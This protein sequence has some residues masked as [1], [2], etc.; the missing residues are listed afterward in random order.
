MLFIIGKLDITILCNYKLDT[1]QY[2]VLGCWPEIL[3]SLHHRMHSTEKVKSIMC[4]FAPSNKNNII[5]LSI[6]I[7]KNSKSI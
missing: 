2:Y 4:W 1:L 6:M 7:E 3:T 5:D